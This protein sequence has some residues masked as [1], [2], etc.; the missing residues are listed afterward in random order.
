MYQ[1]PAF[2]LP[3]LTLVVSPLVALM[4]DQLQHLPPGLPGVCL[5][6]SQTQAEQGALPAVKGVLRG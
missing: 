6:G 1:L 3:G 4:Q 2:K 5:N